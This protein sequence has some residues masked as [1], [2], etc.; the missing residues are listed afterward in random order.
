[1]RSDKM[2]TKRKNSPRIRCTTRLIIIDLIFVVGMLGVY[3]VNHL[4]TRLYVDEIVSITIHD[5]WMALL[6][7][8]P[9]PPYIANY[10]LT[11]QDGAFVGTATFSAG[12]RPPATT[13]NVLIPEEVGEAFLSKL[14]TIRMTEGWYNPSFEMYDDYPKIVISIQTTTE[15]IELYTQSQGEGHI[16]WAVRVGDEMYIVASPTP[17]E[18]FALLQPYLLVDIPDD[19]SEAN[20]NPW[21]EWLQQQYD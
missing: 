20:N 9:T 5:E 11:V 19:M 14:N 7:S 10:E 13:E 21:Y 3:V 6:F 1:M 8:E 17:A 12:G 2:K 18:A 15:T 16:P 4:P